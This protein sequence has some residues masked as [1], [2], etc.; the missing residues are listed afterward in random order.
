MLDA[1]G[2]DADP[3]VFR[4]LEHGSGG[5]RV[6]WI[7]YRSDG[8]ANHGGELLGF[9]V[10]RRAAVRT[11]IAMHHAAARSD[12]AELFRGSRDGDG[13]GGIK[14]PRTERRPGSPLAVDTMTSHDKLRWRSQ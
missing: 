7:R 1:G 4:L 2:I 12:P 13:V 8:D 3:R 9:P 6:I 10:N 14:R 5:R 11:E